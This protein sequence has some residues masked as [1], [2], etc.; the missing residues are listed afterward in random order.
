MSKNLNYWNNNNKEKKT[1][2]PQ[3]EK[4]I[5]IRKKIIDNYLYHLAKIVVMIQNCTNGT[6]NKYIKTTKKGCVHQYS[7]PNFLSSAMFGEIKN[8]IQY[9]E[10]GYNYTV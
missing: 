4:Y 5:K 8:D 3:Y 9:I 1:L 7:G 2:Y 10:Q 6:N